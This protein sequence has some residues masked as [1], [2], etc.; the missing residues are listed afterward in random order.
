VSDT[1]P[2]DPRYWF[3]IWQFVLTLLAI[4]GLVSGAGIAFIFGLVTSLGINTA[5]PGVEQPPLLTL[6]LFAGGLVASALLL[7]PSAYYAL[8]RINGHPI[9]HSPRLPWLL[10]PSLLIFLL[11]VV[12]LFGY[13]IAQ[14]PPLS[15]FLL[16]ILNV[17]AIGLPVLWL[18]YL[19]SRSLPLGSPQRM[20][21]VFGSGLVL[22][23]AIILVLE[24]LAMV[25]FIVIG[26]LTIINQPQLMNQIRELIPS[27]QQGRLSQE[28]F[29]QVLLPWLAKPG[30]ILAALIF[31]GVV[32]PL[33]E[34]AVKP[35]GVW[36]LVAFDL[37][38]AAGF[39]AGALSGA[40]YAFFE[41]LALG[42]SGGGDWTAA[43]SARIATGVIHIFNTALMGWALTRAWQEKRYLNLGLTYLA[44]VLVHGAWN[45]LAVISAIN[46]LLSQQGLQPSLSL[47]ARIGPIAPYL[48]GG[49]TLVMFI[50]MLWMN[51]RLR[52]KS[53]AAAGATNP[54]I[55]AESQNNEPPQAVL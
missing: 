26:V 46:D 15:W 44:V 1:Q 27:I 14:I 36:L 24:I 2:K 16:P 47:V 30:V 48:L 42:G 55:T 37:S 28:Q 45:S 34:E 20:W 19:A 35:I 6:F 4:L 25:A 32:V 5:T 21:G 38:P 7:T 9:G 52:P 29:I 50:L 3:S 31:V 40:G 41:S 23:P 39:T 12:L 51:W 22:G 49:I 53:Q 10:R 33:I 11:P 8:R 17:L 18:L 43:V 54:D 13:W